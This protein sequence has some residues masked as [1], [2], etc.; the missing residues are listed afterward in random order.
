MVLNHRNLFIAACGVSLSIAACGSSGSDKPAVDGSTPTV[1]AAPQGAH[2]GYVIN[3]ISIPLDMAQATSYGLDLGAEKSNAPDGTVDNALQTVL[4]LVQV[5]AP[6]TSLQATISG[7]ITDG[8]IILLADLI[9]TAFD[10]AAAAGLSI[11]LGATP[12]PMPCNAADDCGHHLDGTGTFTIADSSPPNATVTG[13]IT[14]GTF[15]GGPGN[16]S[17]QLAIGDTPISLNLLGARVK[18]TEISESGLTAV[19][20]GGVVPQALIDAVAPI[21]PPLLAPILA[22]ACPAAGGTPPTCGCAEPAA[23]IMGVLNTGSPANCEITAD[24]IKSSAALKILLRADVCS[25]PTCTQPDLF[26]L[27]IKVTAVKASFPGL[28]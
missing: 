13:S 10:N 24:E 15:N 12:T 28:Q 16:L 27:G 2:H 20:G 17:L 26:S 5:A 8:T 11:K 14:S 25:Q 21:L 1:D 9:A 22:D 4:N 6:D 7:A 18:A 3:Q 19:V 23:T